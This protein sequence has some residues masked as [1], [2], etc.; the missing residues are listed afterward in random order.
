VCSCGVARTGVIVLVSTPGRGLFEGGGLIDGHAR[1][2]ILIF[3]VGINELGGEGVFA[4]IGRGR[5]RWRRRQI[6]A[7]KINMREGFGA[8]GFEGGWW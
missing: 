1:G 8:R 3:G 2:T 6:V 5:R 7:I 4:A